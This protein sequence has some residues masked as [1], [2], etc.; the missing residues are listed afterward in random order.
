MASDR[1]NYI[2]SST[3]Q[4][5]VLTHS[6]VNTLILWVQGWAKIFFPAAIYLGI[7]LKDKAMNIYDELSDPETDH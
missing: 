1:N 3:V 7:W 4:Q 2:L 6:K 5:H